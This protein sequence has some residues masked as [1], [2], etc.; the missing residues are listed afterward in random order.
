MKYYSPRVM[1]PDTQQFFQFVQGKVSDAGQQS[2]AYKA[3]YHLF[4]SAQGL[5]K[6]LDEF[7][8]E[9]LSVFKSARTYLTQIQEQSLVA[10]TA[11]HVVNLLTPEIRG[12]VNRDASLSDADRLVLQSALDVYQSSAI[13]TCAALGTPKW[14]DQKR[15]MS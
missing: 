11:H 15:T 7:T 12:I 2:A 5:Y 3:V 8:S 9:N 4:Y 6:T 1:K 13:A 10:L 14:V